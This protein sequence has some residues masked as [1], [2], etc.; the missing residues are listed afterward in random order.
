MTGLQVVCGAGT[1][2]DSRRQGE[3]MERLRARVARQVRRFG[4]TDADADRVVDDILD[5][6]NTFTFDPEKANGAKPE[7]VLT[8]FITNRCKMAMRVLIS[9][10]ARDTRYGEAMMA[11]NDDQ[12]MR[13]DVPMQIDV[14]D[15]LERLTPQERL[16]CE[17]I[18]NGVPRQDIC[19]RHGLSW[20]QWDEL[21]AGIRSRFAALGLHEWLKD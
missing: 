11:G 13:R 15:A 6:W 3:E 17:A 7:T 19:D 9:D 14:R 1:E 20:Y 21:I 12:T 4:F 2:A 5:A 18:A 16:V 8:G 10:R